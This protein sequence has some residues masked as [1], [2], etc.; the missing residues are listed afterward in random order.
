[1]TPE[2]RRTIAA[3]AEHI[4]LRVGLNAA[5]FAAFFANHSANFLRSGHIREARNY[6]RLAD[7]ISALRRPM[8][9]NWEGTCP[10]ALEIVPE[11]ED[12][13]GIR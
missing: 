7:V 4:R 13:N 2:E 3:V 12:S 10:I 6:K 1:M 8:R 9:R 5:D 11:E